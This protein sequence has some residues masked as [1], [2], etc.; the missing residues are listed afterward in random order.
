MAKSGW[1]TRFLAL[2]GTVLVWLPIVMTFALSAGGSLRAGDLHFDYLMPAE[3][4]PAALAGGGL[5][6]WASLRAHAHRRL[7]G[8]CLGL[9]VVFLVGGQALAVAT[10]LASGEIGPTGWQWLLVAGSL[11]GYVA[12]VIVLGVGGVLLVLEV[13]RRRV[14]HGG[15]E[16]ASPG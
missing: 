3:L 12:A 5:L 9:M 6:L 10:G 7:I 4:F 2:V 11:A 15:S 8:G 16:P 13:F 1:L 14:G